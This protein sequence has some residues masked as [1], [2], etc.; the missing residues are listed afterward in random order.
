[1]LSLHGVLLEIQGKGVLLAGSPGIGKSETA[2]TL[3]TRGHRFIAD[4]A[5]LFKRSGQQLLGFADKAQ[6]GLL[7]T[8]NLG[9]IDVVQLFGPNVL[10]DEIALDFIITLNHNLPDTE[11]KLKFELVD[12]LMDNLPIPSLSL[13]VAHGH[14]LAI[15]I[16]TAVKLAFMPKSARIERFLAK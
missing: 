14:N 15:L 12:K 4:D 16:E 3:L 11:P 2:L 10:V 9:L 5:P 7:H 13:A 6:Q 1:M 8:R